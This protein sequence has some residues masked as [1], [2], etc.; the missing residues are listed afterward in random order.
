MNKNA[1]SRV[2]NK[3]ESIFFSIK[4]GLVKR[5]AKV[6]KIVHWMMAFRLVLIVNYPPNFSRF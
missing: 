5:H 2:E 4:I 1:M 6:D 3:K